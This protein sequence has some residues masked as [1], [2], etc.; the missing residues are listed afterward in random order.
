[1]P[2]HLVDAPRSAAA[3]Q[4]RTAAALAQGE[5]V[6]PV[7]VLD[8]TL[9][10][11][12]DVSDKRVA[13]LSGGLRAL[14][15]DCGCGQPAGAPL[16]RPRRGVARLC[17]E[18]GAT[19]VFAEADPWPYARRRDAA[20]AERVPLTSPGHHRQ[21]IRCDPQG[22]R[23][24]L[25]YLYPLQSRWKSLPL[26]TPGTWRLHRMAGAATRCARPDR[27]DPRDLHDSRD[28]PG[29]RDLGRPYLPRFLSPARPKGCAGWPR[30]RAAAMRRSAG[31]ERRAT[32]WIWTGPHTFAL[33]AFAWSRHLRA[34]CGRLHRLKTHGCRGKKGR[35][36]LAQRAHLGEFYQSSSIISPG[37]RPESSGQS[38]SVPWRTIARDLR[39]GAK[40]DG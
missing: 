16:R 34:G 3:R 32:A 4:F 40:D 1:M 23:N 31:M 38:A 29:L 8:P 33:S 26:P 5:P 22:R 21:A 18:T 37:A 25:H 12:S 19:A 13:F 36:D 14:D 11:A 35:R 2:D 39:R 27:H 24:R 6:I 9:L 15:A 28:L 7:F 10:Q 17:A 30:S 20:V